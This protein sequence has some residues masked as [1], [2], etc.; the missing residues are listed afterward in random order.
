[1]E[2]PYL[3][4]QRA[5]AAGARGARRLDALAAAFERAC[6]DWALTPVAAL[7]GGSDALVVDVS[8]ADGAPAVL[9]VPLALDLSPAGELEVLRRGAGYAEVLRWTREPDYAWLCAR[10]G[11]PLADA[12][13]APRPLVEALCDVLTQCWFTPTG[14]DLALFQSGHDKAL[15]LRGYLTDHADLLAAHVTPEAY[16]RAL[17]Y[18]EQRAAQHDLARCVVAHGDPHAHNALRVPASDPPRY[19]FVDP[20]GVVIEPEYDL[21]V[22]LRELD[23]AELGPDPAG[24]LR[25]LCTLLADRTGADADVVWQWAF[26]ERATTGVALWSLGLEQD[27]RAL[28][29]VLDAL[30]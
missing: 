9:K 14:G 10:Q 16:A 11:A 1:M 27:A 24:V 13:L 7:S 15:V 17:G 19:V 12:H 28:W 18:A 8:C 26:I 23:A 5:A 3:V 6:A 2:I 30:S 29:E 4:R 25:D 21:G 20:D 22:T